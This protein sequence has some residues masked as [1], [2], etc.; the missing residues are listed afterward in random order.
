MSAIR[1]ICGPGTPDEGVIM[2]QT[3]ELGTNTPR[4]ANGNITSKSYREAAGKAAEGMIY[5]SL[6]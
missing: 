4:Y 3:R 6:K 2:K 1:I 5:A